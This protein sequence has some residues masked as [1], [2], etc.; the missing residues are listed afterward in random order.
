MKMLR[1]IFKD[2]HDAIIVTNKGIDQ[3][4]AALSEWSKGQKPSDASIQVRNVA[5]TELNFLKNYWDAKK[6]SGDAAC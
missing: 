1:I 5:E 4:I 2:S 6:G 3:V